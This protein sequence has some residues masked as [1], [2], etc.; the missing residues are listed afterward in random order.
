MAA[1]DSLLNMGSRDLE[2]EPDLA[3]LLMDQGIDTDCVSFLELPKCGPI[4]HT[5]P[6]ISLNPGSHAGLQH[7]M[8]SAP[9]PAFL[10]QSAPPMYVNTNVF[11]GPSDTG[12]VDVCG[13]SENVSLPW[14]SPGI[15]M[16]SEGSAEDAK[17]AQ[18]LRRQAAVQAK[19]RKAQ[20]RFREKQKAKMASLEHEVETLKSQLGQMKVQ[21][22]CLS[23]QNGLLTN[24]LDFKD[25]QMVLLQNE[26]KVL[27]TEGSTVIAEKQAIE[28]SNCKQETREGTFPVSKFKDLNEDELKKLWKTYVQGLSQMMVAAT[29]NPK[30]RALDDRLEGVLKE[31]GELLCKASSLCP[32]SMKKLVSGSCEGEVPK[33]QQKMDKLWRG[34]LDALTLSETQ[35]VLLMSL[36]DTFVGKMKDIAEE[37]SGLN[38]KIQECSGGSHDLSSTIE[39]CQKSI[40]LT[41]VMER[42][43]DTIH[44]EHLCHADFIG[45]FFRNILRKEQRA[46]IYVQSYPFY[47]DVLYIANLVWQKKTTPKPECH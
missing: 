20:K 19:N 14:E 1:L 2:G 8:S 47:P 7:S 6:S 27:S 10:P 38:R 4:P 13:T 31:I 46:R 26:A 33:D 43:R 22:D 34:L 41:S 42:L 25:R 32:S 37:R 29:Q 35:E 23:S 21:Y 24:V 30:D 12:C 28:V 15:D 16:R 45:G 5:Q 11:S 3:S 17:T 18:L 44:R 36:R 39:T 9:A 40:E